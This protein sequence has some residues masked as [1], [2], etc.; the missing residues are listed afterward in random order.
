M[1]PEF[2]FFK[3]VKPRMTRKEELQEAARQNRLSSSQSFSKT[4]D[5]GNAGSYG[6]ASVGSR[7]KKQSMLKQP[8]AQTADSSNRREKALSKSRLQ[9]LQGD[10]P[11]ARTAQ[12]HRADRRNVHNSRR[13]QQTENPEGTVKFH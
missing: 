1:L 2:S 6:R 11:D 3:T 10:Q 7:R 12:A 13:I 9:V 4:R 8:S 5:R